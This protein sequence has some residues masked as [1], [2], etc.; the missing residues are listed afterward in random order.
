[1]LFGMT[2]ATLQDRLSTPEGFAKAVDAK[3]GALG[4]FWTL[5]VLGLLAVGL[6][7]IQLGSATD[8]DW[9]LMGRFFMDPEAIEFTGRR[10]ARGELLR[11]F[12]VY[13]PLILL[14][15][16]LIALIVH[17]ATRRKNGAKLFRDFQQRGYVGRQRFTGLRVKNG[18][19]QTDI[20]LI[21][22]PQ[23]PE[24]TLD[25]AAQQY[26]AEL[27]S[28]DKKGLKAASTAAVKAGVLQGV[29]AARLS[30]SLP[31]DLLVAPAQGK[32]EYVVVIPS[33]ADGG[34]LRIIPIKP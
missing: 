17:F 2:I 18:R 27:G 19:Q 26:S 15:L 6:N 9:Y 22:N 1:M 23:V 20:V 5:L 31:G 34:K 4:A 11:Y 7:L 25:A 3:S 12:A 30:A 29:S 21:S 33:G 10:A 32:S 24:E 16:A 28:L 8:W 14:P 13:G